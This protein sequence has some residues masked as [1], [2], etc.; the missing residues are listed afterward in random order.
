MNILLALICGRVVGNGGHYLRTIVSSLKLV[1][2][3]YWNKRQAQRQFNFKCYNLEGTSMNLTQNTLQLHRCALHILILPQELENYFFNSNFQLNKQSS[4][5]L[6]QWS[7]HKFCSKISL[8][9][10]IKAQILGK[11]IS[12]LKLTPLECL[13]YQKL[14]NSKEINNYGW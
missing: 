2:D 10:K 5:L 9:L 7:W 3:C 4:I 8:S 12:H 14:H 6:I 11:V 13:G 1:M